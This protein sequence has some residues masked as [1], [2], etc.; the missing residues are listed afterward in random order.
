MTTES[1]VYSDIVDTRLSR[2]AALLG[3][4]SVAAV[5]GIGGLGRGAR[6]ARASSTLT[7][8]ELTKIYDES[9]HVPAGYTASPLVRWGDPI[10]A[11]AKPFDPKA[12]SAEAQAGQFGYNCD[13]IGYMP[14]PVGSKSSDHGL[15]CVNNE[16]TD[17]HIM[18]PGMTEDDQAKKVTKEQ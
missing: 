13:F 6:A 14:L 2:R 7:F 16:Y 9:H 12:L 1:R 18:F 17:P 8:E 3:L 4:T 10:V 5:A 11:G 15:L